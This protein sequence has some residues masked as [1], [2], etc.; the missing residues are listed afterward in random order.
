LLTSEIACDEIRRNFV[1]CSWNVSCC[2]AAWER[3]F[4]SNSPAA[5]EQRPPA[6][7]F[8]WAWSEVGVDRAR[9]NIET[10]GSA[11]RRRWPRYALNLPVVVRGTDR[12]SGDFVDLAVVL[13]VSRGGALLAV[14]RP[15]PHASRIALQPQRASGRPAPA[16]RPNAEPRRWRVVRLRFPAPLSSDR[17][18]YLLKASQPQ[19]KPIWRLRTA[20][21]QVFAAATHRAA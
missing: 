18:A 3:K 17:L 14:N 10:A 6:A 4:R 5:G 1:K 15:L 7:F 19:L 13:N 16:G 20:L 2:F 11:E 21:A 9:T 8:N 12:E